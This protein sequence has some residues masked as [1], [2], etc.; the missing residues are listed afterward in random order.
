MPE[1]KKVISFAPRK[2]GSSLRDWVSY[3]GN[4]KR[5]ESFYIISQ[6]ACKIR[7]WVVLLHP[8]QE[9]HCVRKSKIQEWHVHRHIELTA[10]LS[11]DK[12]KKKRV[13]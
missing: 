1:R 11:Q 12:T 5:N 9:T 2:R 6:K 8:L 10:V 3:K 4:K 13:R 7:K